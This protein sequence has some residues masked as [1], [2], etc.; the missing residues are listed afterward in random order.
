MRTVGFD[1]RYRYYQTQFPDMDGLELAQMICEPIEYYDKDWVT[2]RTTQI[3]DCDEDAVL[4]KFVKERD[5]HFRREA[6]VAVYCYDE[7]G[8]GS[9]INTMRLLEVGKPILGFYHVDAQNCGMNVTNVLQLALEFPALFTV[10]RYHSIEDIQRVL[11][12]WLQ[13]YR[14]SYVPPNPQSG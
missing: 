5:E 7:A 11:V 4:A 9:G 8:M 13:N 12:A 10:A 2:Y 6:Q 14:S 1:T 3:G